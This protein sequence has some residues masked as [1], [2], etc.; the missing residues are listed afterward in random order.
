VLNLLRVTE[1]II[2]GT[3]GLADLR[4]DLVVRLV[5]LR[6]QA[7]EL[8][9]DV[10]RQPELLVALELVHQERLV[11]DV[12]Q[13]FQTRFKAR[14]EQVQKLTRV[15]HGKHDFLAPLFADSGFET[16]AEELPAYLTMIGG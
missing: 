10:V 5:V 8:F 4:T 14:A 3:P 7:P 2:D 16:S 13:G 9:T 12:L 11:A 6:V 15:Y 1:A